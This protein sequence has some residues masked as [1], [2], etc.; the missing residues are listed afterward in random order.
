MKEPFRW[1]LV[2]FQQQLLNFQNKIILTDQ[3]NIRDKENRESLN[4]KH[5]NNL[6][7]IPMKKQNVFGK[8]KQIKQISKKGNNIRESKKQVSMSEV[9][10]SSNFFIKLKQWGPQDKPSSISQAK[11]NINKL[12]ENSSK[13]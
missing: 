13:G 7:N 2:Q 6:L 3:T 10:I 12:K 9:D 5:R 11:I 4:S 1:D 8:K